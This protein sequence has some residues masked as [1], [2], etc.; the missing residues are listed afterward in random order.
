MSPFG[1]RVTFH[2]INYL[3]VAQLTQSPRS[4]CKKTLSPTQFYYK[5]KKKKIIIVFHFEKYQRKVRRSRCFAKSRDVWIQ[6]RRKRIRKTSV[7]RNR[8]DGFTFSRRLPF[9]FRC[10]DK[11]GLIEGETTEGFIIIRCRGSEPITASRIDLLADNWNSPC[12]AR[13]GFHFPSGVALC[14][15]RASRLNRIDKLPAQGRCP[16]GLTSPC[17]QSFVCPR[18]ASTFDLAHISSEVHRPI[19]DLYIGVVV[20]RVFAE[21]K[22]LRHCGKLI[23]QKSHL[24]KRAKMSIYTT[25]RR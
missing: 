2:C 21:N 22:D 15:R 4:D 6:T 24:T 18:R 14:A 8:A 20:Q 12:A 13:A 5:K 1:Q 25:G 10:I 7:K 11:F 3:P 19:R 23:L 16:C 17:N 9:N